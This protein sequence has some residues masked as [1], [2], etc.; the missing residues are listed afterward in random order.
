MSIK[1]PGQKVISVSLPQ[2]L[3]DDIDARAASL[4]LSRS[5]Y[6][7]L[8]A[9]QDIANP[10]PPEIPAATGQPPAAPPPT[11]ARDLTA[12]VYDFLLQAVPALEQYEASQKTEGHAEDADAEGEA[13]AAAPEAAPTAQGTQPEQQALTRLWKF[14]MMEKDE[15]LRH[16]YLRSQELGYNI[17]LPRAIKEWLQMHRALWAATHRPE[18]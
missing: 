16:K 6:L 15:I 12:E 2:T 8:L 5:A 17:G 18:D 3:I 14:F 4:G 1:L 9:R 13:P 11:A 10:A 7:S